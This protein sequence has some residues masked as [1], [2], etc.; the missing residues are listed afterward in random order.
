MRILL[1][2]LTLVACGD[3][4]KGDDVVAEMPYCEETRTEVGLDEV[5]PL[6]FSGAQVLALA[7]GEWT[8]TLVFDGGSET[9][10]A[11]GVTALDATA[12]HVD[13]EAVYPTG[14]E[15]ADI[16]VICDDYVEVQVFSSFVSE[17]GSFDEAWSVP[18][19]SFDGLQ[20]GASVDFDDQALQGSYRFTELDPSEYDEVIHFL[21]ASF[22]GAATSG[23]VDA[24]AT[25]QE[26]CTGSDCTAW[27]ANFTVATW[28]EVTSR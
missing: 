27:A 16:A 13:S 6:G 15:V 12:V 10:L 11:I 21:T 4:N 8:S 18:L 19:R 23:V 20:A 28:G 9:P 24:Q 17:D 22:D 5:S 1:P 26:D 25:G 3:E 2:L 7:E 14:G